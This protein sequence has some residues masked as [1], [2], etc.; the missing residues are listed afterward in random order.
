M[1]IVLTG[2]GTGGH[3]MPLVAVARELE[4]LAARGEMPVLAA[5]EPPL[6]ILYLGVVTDRE[7]ATLTAA[8]IPFRHVPS[9]KIR[10]YLSGAPQTIG[11]L[12]FRVPLGIL[13]ALG[14]LFVVMPDVV[15][16]K[17]GYG[18]LPVVFVSWLYRIPVLLHETDLVPGLANQRLAR[19]AS[20]I[21]VGFREAEK[22]FP[23]AKVFVTGTPLREGFQ[24]VPAT[25]E[26]RARLGLH[27]EKPVIFIAGGSQGSRRI[28]SVVL[29]TLPRLLTE[30]QVLHQVGEKN[31]DAVRSFVT[32]DLKHV[33]EL[34]DYHLVASLSEAD[35]VASL[36]AADLVVSRAGGTALAEIAAV[37]KPCLLIPLRE[38]AQD[39]QWE[40]AYFFR[41]HGA[42]VVLDEQNL[43][44]SLF[45]TTV[46]RIL[47]APVDRRLMAERVRLLHRPT[48]TGDIATTL[49]ALA[50][51]RVPRRVLAAQGERAR[52]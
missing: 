46:R 17:G 5:G 44:P 2:G 22:Y 51:G 50:Q 21:A 31:Y 15:F 12:L 52:A 36:A 32:T 7:R 33:P 40:N 37:G 3:L 25:S 18:S 16:S 39:H 42:A 13:R 45:Y 20:A 1:R 48:A 41:E 11:D 14:V 19:Y 9:G 35:M 23:P 6:E 28:N 8:G 49:V 30:A 10:R 24:Q 29:A 47:S 27:G 38:S 4:R 26:A 34:S 43:T